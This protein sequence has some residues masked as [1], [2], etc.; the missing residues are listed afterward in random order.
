L[1]KY[2]YKGKTYWAVIWS[3]DSNFQKINRNYFY[4]EFLKKNETWDKQK[5][6]M[7]DFEVYN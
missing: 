7:I 6:E 1:E 5:H 3:K 4:C 2:V